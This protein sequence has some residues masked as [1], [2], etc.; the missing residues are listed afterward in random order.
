MIL[1]LGILLKRC[2]GGIDPEY[3]GCRDP[4]SGVHIGLD[5]G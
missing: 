3:L 2:I 4:F 5:M 1:G